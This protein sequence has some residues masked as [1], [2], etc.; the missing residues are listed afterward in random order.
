MKNNR[1]LKAISVIAGIFITLFVMT[2]LAIVIDGGRDR[3]RPSDVAIVF[4]NTVNSDG[5]I[6]PRLAARLDTAVTLYHKDLVSR[7]IVSGSTGKEGVDEAVAMKRY[8]VSRQ[9]PADAVI[10]DSAGNTTADTA[11]NSVQIMRQHGYQSA[12]LVSQ[13]FHIP[14]A[15]MAFHQCGG[16]TLYGAKLYNAHPHYFEWRDIYSLTREVVALY[17]YYFKHS[18]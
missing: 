1:F 18:C 16:S 8:L 9:I 12:L 2:A 10:V 14:R 5:S 13:Y 11:K 3:I 17:A 7:F 15:R 4:G 6:S